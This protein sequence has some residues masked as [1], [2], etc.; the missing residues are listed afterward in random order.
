MIRNTGNVT[1][2]EVAKA[3]G[4]SVATVSRVFNKNYYVS[5]EVTQRV[6]D[7]AE[8]LGYFP[9]FIARSLKTNSTKTIAFL[10]SD[11][12]NWYHI[13]IAK[14]IEDIVKK[15]NYNLI[16]CSTENNKERELAYLE[17]LLSK[18]IDALILNSTG[19]NDDF[20][21]KM[22][23]KIPMV[24]IHRRI[25]NPE[26]VGD[27]A[28]TNNTMGTYIL[29]KQLITL[30]HKK[31][32]A[33]K[34]PAHLSNSQERFLGF[35]KAM[36]EVDVDVNNNYP[37][38]YD[39]NFTL[40]SGYS[41]IEFLCNL[42]DKPT[43]IIS[44]NNMMTLGALK[45]LKTKNINTPEDISFVAYD[46]IQNIELMA[47]RPT[48]ANF[49]PYPIGTQIGKAIL[50]RIENNSMENREFIFEP[51]IIHGN[52]IGIPTNNLE[53]KKIY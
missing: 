17:L 21:L 37:Y 51:T 42:S 49:E 13:S 5:D 30:G 20:V 48:V 26:F 15:Q 29:T 2:R 14:A 8:N 47:S 35:A 34:G 38:T 33:I 1:S 9:N 7:A 4:V 50:E 45:C 3:A 18:N 12:S 6:L 23:K 25:Q 44:F 22:N 46:G 52:T 32:F 43:A 53:N 27:I 10:M 31:I 41:A 16:V 39:G 19:M 11:I 28:D 24:L 40:E 36:S